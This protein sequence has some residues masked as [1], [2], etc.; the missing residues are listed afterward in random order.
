MFAGTAVGIAA[1][2]PGVLE[3]NTV[4]GP[5]ALAPAGAASANGASPTVTHKAARADLVAN[6]FLATTPRMTAL[7]RLVVS[8]EHPQTVLQRRVTSAPQVQ[9]YPPPTSCTSVRWRQ[10]PSGGIDVSN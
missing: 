1:V 3:E 7:R 2:K 4:T 8:T 6:R 10:S 5:T 9:R